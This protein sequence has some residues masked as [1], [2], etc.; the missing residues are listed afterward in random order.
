MATE[1]ANGA[2][3]NFWQSLWTIE[4]VILI[5][6]VLVCLTVVWIGRYDVIPASSDNDSIAGV[7][8]LDRWTG[9]VWWIRANRERLVT[10]YP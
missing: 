1:T 9:R 3:Q 2:N 8:Q 5:S 10:P 4:R 6:V 7:Y